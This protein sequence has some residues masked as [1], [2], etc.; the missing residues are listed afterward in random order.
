MLECI[1]WKVRLFVF[2]QSYIFFIGSVSRRDVVSSRLDATIGRSYWIIL[3][4]S[5]RGVALS[6]RYVEPI[7]SKLT[8]VR[9]TL[10]YKFKPKFQKCMALKVVKMD[11]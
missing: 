4:S 1:L 11:S 7:V 5:P 3:S 6:R 9:L 8:L 2:F 10:C